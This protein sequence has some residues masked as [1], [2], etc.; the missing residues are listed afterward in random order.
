MY[1]CQVKKDKKPKITKESWLKARRITGYIKPYRF[2]FSISVLFLLA[3]SVASMAFP[4]LMGKL[5]G[6]SSSAQGFNFDGLSNTKTVVIIL[7]SIFAIQSVFSFFRILLSSIVTENVLADMRI[8]AY[9]KLISL[10]INFFNKNK[11][12]ELTSRISAD[13]T[14]LQDTF[15][16][17]LPEFIRQ[18]IVIIIGVTFLAI[19]SVKLALIMLATIP[20]MAI[21]AV[22]FGRFIKK[23]S[24]QAQDKVAES[25]SIVEETLTA[26][27]SVK[28]YASEYFE[29]RRYKKATEEIKALSI[30]GAIWRGAFVSFIIFCMFGSIVFVIWQGVVMK[31]AGE[32]SLDQL[33][34]FVMFSVF[35][36]ASFGSIP[37][38][39][40]KIQVAIGATERLMD[41]IDEKAEVIE[42]DMPVSSSQ[43][44]LGKVEF[45]KVDFHYESRSDIPVLKNISFQVE[46]GMQIAIVGPSGAGKSTIASL[47]LRFYEPVSGVIKFDG[48]NIQ[49]QPL[50]ELRSQMALVPQEV[51]LFGGTIR[52]NIQYGKQDATIDE[53]KEA[54]RKANALEF[55]E[56]FPEGFET[57]VGERGIQLSG[58]Q[59]QRIAIARAVLK[60][61][62]ILILDEATS[63]LDSESERLVQE[64]LEKLMEGRTSF[65]IAH[66]LST[67]KKADLILVLEHGSLVEVG[68]H[69][70]LVSTEN[71]LYKKLSSLQYVAQEA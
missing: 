41:I 7:F 64:A 42:L 8:K 17:V 53:I 27:A 47:L 3:S 54:A 44:I 34:S 38:L 11:T 62:S 4:L 59:R 49:E 65:V 37:E 25:T 70:D 14:L 28:A 33:V 52:E 63:S 66:R 12:G 39:Y 51:I 23:L 29:V 21:V 57:I 71:G 68:T 60:D 26:I 40:S 9:R 1:F 67:I 2:Y 46:P 5:F 6:S 43:R 18:F 61:P 13:I 56:K 55:I 16:T 35:I 19:I 50:S 36:G 24:S 10:P 69:Q 22:F 15:N 31:D 45:E 32:I 20:V 30:K 48:V 58:G